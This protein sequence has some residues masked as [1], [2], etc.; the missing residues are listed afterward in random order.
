MKLKNYN[1]YVNESVA[2]NALRQ[3]S[4]Q[5]I[6]EAEKYLEEGKDPNWDYKLGYFYIDVTGKYSVYYTLWR[7]NPNHDA[8]MNRYI[9]NLSTDLTTAVE[10][11]KKAA[12]R[13]PVSIDRYGTQAG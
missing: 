5:E 10:K 11:A 4:A 6:E 12:G 7:W 9:C 3:P 8:H 13:V 2:R 1:E